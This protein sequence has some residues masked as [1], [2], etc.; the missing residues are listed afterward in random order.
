MISK[1]PPRDDLDPLDKEILERALQASL[2]VLKTSIQSVEDES[3]EALEQLLR[4]ELLEIAS[5]NGIRDPET[6]K[7]ILLRTRSPISATGSLWL[8]SQSSECA[9]GE[10]D[11]ERE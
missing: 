10:V 8:T 2:S 4:V 9:C 3:D 11:G 6:L 5:L 1:K 7:D